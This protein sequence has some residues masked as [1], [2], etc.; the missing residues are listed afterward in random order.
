MN[1]L[2]P[3]ELM[4]LAAYLAEDGLTGYHWEESPLV[5]QRLYAPVQGNARARE[6]KWVVWGAGWGKGIGDIRDNISIVNE[7]NI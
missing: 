5:I 4:S 7:E 2:I 1:Y 3:P 6:Q